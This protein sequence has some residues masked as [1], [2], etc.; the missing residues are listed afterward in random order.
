MHGTS[1]ACKGFEVFVSQLTYKRKIR[2]DE[3][4]L[5]KGTIKTLLFFPGD[6]KT[7]VDFILPIIWWLITMKGRVVLFR[8]PRMIFC[9]CLH[10]VS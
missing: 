2:K 7:D 8:Y 3:S 9:F 6:W 5:I 10:M 1:F 4:G